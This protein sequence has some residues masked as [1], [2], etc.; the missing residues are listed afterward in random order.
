MTF[1]GCTALERVTIPASVA[2]INDYAFDSF[3]DGLT[4]VVARGSVAEQF[5]AEHG[6]TVEYM[7]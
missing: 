1:E 5:A 7:D 2:E 4:L 6:L 3:P